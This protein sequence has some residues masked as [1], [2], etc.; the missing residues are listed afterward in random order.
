M[1]APEP[2]KPPREDE[3]DAH[4]GRRLSKWLDASFD[5]AHPKFKLRNRSLALMWWRSKLTER[6]F[7]EALTGSL[8]HL[9]WYCAV[10]GQFTNAGK[11]ARA[12]HR[13]GA[14]SEIARTAGLRFYRQELALQRNNLKRL[15]H[16]I[17]KFE[18]WGQI[19]LEI[20]HGETGWPMTNTNLIRQVKEH[21]KETDANLDGSRSAIAEFITRVE[22]DSLTWR[23]KV[24]ERNRI[25]SK[26]LSI[27]R[28]R[29][30]ASKKHHISGT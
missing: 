25:A 14:D 24:V 5:A 20:R 17:K 27:P 8:I 4:V 13:A 3:S 29:K 16:R 23:N 6:Y 28:R 26:P 9:A 19:A 10:R 11:A 21:L 22:L 7:Q 18:R 12:A 2:F 1:T 15:D 30:A